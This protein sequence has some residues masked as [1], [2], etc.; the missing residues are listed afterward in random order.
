MF[1][2]GLFRR[3]FKSNAS[4]DGGLERQ[5]G[6]QL[7]LFVHGLSGSA[8]TSW[9]EML[10]VLIADPDL[11]DVTV[12]SYA[13]PTK[14][15]RLP[16]TKRLAG[17]RELARGLR[18]HL[19]A[20]H[21]DAEEIVLV[22]HSLGGVIIRQFVVEECK[23]G[24][25]DVLK[26][27]ALF[28]SP[29]RGVQMAETGHRFSWKH[30]HLRQLGRESDLLEGCLED[31]ISLRIESLMQT[32]YVVGGVD[33]V[34]PPESACIRVGA[35]NVATL[36]NYGH[37]DIIRPIDGDDIRFKVLKGL[38]KKAL[39]VYATPSRTVMLSDN[40]DVLFDVYSAASER[41]YASRVTD[42]QV[43][44]AAQNYNLW[45]SGPSGTGKTAA[46]RRCAIQRNFR[47]CHIQLGSHKGL[48]SLGLVRAI[49]SELHEY[50]GL[51]FDDAKA[52][53]LP[54][55]IHHFKTVM[56]RLSSTQKFAILVEELPLSSGEELSH[57]LTSTWHIVAAMDASTLTHQVLWMY[58]SISAP[59]L[60]QEPYHVKLRE[61]IQFIELSP[62]SNAELQ[63]LV[64]II[65]SE[66]RMEIGHQYLSSI[67]SSA[68]GS[69]RFVKIL[70]RSFRQRPELVSAPAEMLRQIATELFGHE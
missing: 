19:A 68:K 56:R 1:F 6:T 39:R 23:A 2:K 67:I 69:P 58:S 20:H 12:G 41:F 51:P 53:T 46:L 5:T 10:R 47:L 4:E 16:F 7:I 14:L 48:N 64:A 63:S 57:F 44:D 11:K 40:G 70:F 38:I 35:E 8:E 43:S 21:P 49:C 27:I 45:V 3:F 42:S 52:D 32:I 26:G 9:K 55:I 65:Q 34:V 29:F 59:T 22:G 62:W 18:T 31:W 17:I 13:Y 15:I 60:T 33:T 50:A 28:A 24:R 66:L 54:N 37:S 36:M 25:A 61:R 30:R